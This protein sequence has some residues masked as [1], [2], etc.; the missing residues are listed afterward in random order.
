MYSTSESDDTVTLI[1]VVERKRRD[2]KKRRKKN[3]VMGYFY[4]KG[5]SRER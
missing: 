5:R 2:G 4:S 1:E 3:K